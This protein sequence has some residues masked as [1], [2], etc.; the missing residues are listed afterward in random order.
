M[1]DTRK[2]KKEPVVIDY[3]AAQALFRKHKGALTRAKKK[4][5][6][7]IVEAVDAF[8]AD[9]EHAG[10]PLPDAWHTWERAKDD[11]LMDI[12]RSNGGW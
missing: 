7:A 1:S 11:A 4:S 10:F 12:A 3:A 6:E 8:Y 5:P 9:F 2:H